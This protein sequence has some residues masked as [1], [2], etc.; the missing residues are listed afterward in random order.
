MII[1]NTSPG[2]QLYPTTRPCK[3]DFTS[4]PEDSMIVEKAPL[5]FTCI[6]RFNH[7]NTTSRWNQMIIRWSISKTKASPTPSER[8]LS[9]Q[10]KRIL[11]NLSLWPPELLKLAEVLISKKNISRSIEMS[12]FSLL[13]SSASTSQFGHPELPELAQ[14]LISKKNVSLKIKMRC[15]HIART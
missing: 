2:L 14:L 13:Q 9:L 4:K 5:A 3:Y 8:L 1:T 15:L 10:T 12:R 11:N 7:A 6:H